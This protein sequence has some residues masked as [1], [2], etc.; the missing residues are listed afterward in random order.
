[1]VIANS[2][3]LFAVNP[4]CSGAKILYLPI[5]SIILVFNTFSKTLEKRFKREIGRNSPSSLGAN[6][7][8]IGMTCPTLNSSRKHFCCKHLLYN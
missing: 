6:V 3:E 4:Y 7:L 2:V 1:M 5:K 8:G